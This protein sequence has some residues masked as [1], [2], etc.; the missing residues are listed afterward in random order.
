MPLMKPLEFIDKLSAYP[1]SAVAP[2][3]LFQTLAV[4]GICTA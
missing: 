1:S 3:D 4:T 2:S